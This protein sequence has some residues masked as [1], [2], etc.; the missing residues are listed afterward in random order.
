MMWV[1]LATQY[2]HKY[3]YTYT[4]CDAATAL[5]AECGLWLWRGGT[6]QS[7]HYVG[8]YFSVAVGTSPRARHWN[9]LP[10]LHS[11][12]LSVV[13]VRGMV[14][15]MC[16]IELRGSG[17]IHVCQPFRPLSLCRVFCLFRHAGRDHRFDCQFRLST[18]P[19]VTTDLSGSTV[20][21]DRSDRSVCVIPSHR[22]EKLSILHMGVWWI[23]VALDVHGV[24]WTNI[25][26][27]GWLHSYI[28]IG[29]LS[30]ATAFSRNAWVPQAARSLTRVLEF[31][32][33]LLVR[34]CGYYYYYLLY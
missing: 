21:S 20:C 28:S 19:G 3:T 22:K 17:P 32:E 30:H 12:C 15:L 23:A 31:H 13:Q 7:C 10:R 1:N 18:M 14:E 33:L 5:K 9:L 11:A 8:L 16:K 6:V 27:M 2:V 34:K 24:L 25:V 29:N 4:S 26:C